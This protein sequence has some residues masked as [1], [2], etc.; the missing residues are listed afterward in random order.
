MFLVILINSG[1]FFAALALCGGQ[2]TSLVV[3]HGLVVEM[4]MGLVAP[5]YMG[6]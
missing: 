5:R 1:L 2:C 3:V 6:S 4:R